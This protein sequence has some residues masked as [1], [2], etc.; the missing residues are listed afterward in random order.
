MATDQAAQAQA[1]AQLQAD[2]DTQTALT[3]AYDVAQQAYTSSEQAYTNDQAT[4]VQVQA[5]GDTNQAIAIAGVVFASPSQPLNST[6]TGSGPVNI[7]RPK[8]A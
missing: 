7:D 1:L 3:A 4:S 2:M 5:Q 8:S 6:A